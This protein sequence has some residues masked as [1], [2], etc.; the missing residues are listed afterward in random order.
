MVRRCD[1]IAGDVCFGLDQPDAGRPILGMQAARAGSWHATCGLWAYT[2][3]RARCTLCMYPP[4]RF[5]GW[6]RGLATAGPLLFQ[7]HQ[8]AGLW[9]VPCR[10]V[11]TSGSWHVGRIGVR[12]CLKNVTSSKALLRKFAG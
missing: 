6:V 9:I 12:S 11:R 2:A 3:H 8:V 4:S 1:D 10:S 7:T 5:A